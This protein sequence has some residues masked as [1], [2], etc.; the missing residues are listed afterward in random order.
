MI[1][2]VIFDW[3]EVLTTGASPDTAIGNIAAAFNTD[4]ETAKRLWR[5]NS[6]KLMRGQITNADFWRAIAAET[7]RPAPENADSIWPGWEDLMPD[8]GMVEFVSSLKRRGLKVGIISNILPFSEQVIRANGGYDGYDSVI[9]SCLVGTIKPD[10]AVY[11]MSLD[12][13]GLKPEDCIYVD[14]RPVMLEP[15]AALGMKTVLA[16]NPAQIIRDVEAIIQKEA[17]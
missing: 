11:R 5:E 13:L 7:G 12:E 4:T 2:A 1:K 10:P 14:D 8:A 16:E 3:G 15:A 17:G 6:G 9:L